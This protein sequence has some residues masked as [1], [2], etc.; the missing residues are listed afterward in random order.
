MII[1]FCIGIVLVAC[2]GWLL[3]I[4]WLNGAAG[5]N[6][7]TLCSFSYATLPALLF[8]NQISRLEAQVSRTW[9][10]IDTLVLV[11]LWS[12]P[13][14][15]SLS[16]ISSLRF[17]YVSTLLMGISVFAGRFMNVDTLALVLVLQ[18]VLQTAL[19]PSL[20]S[21]PWRHVM[22]ALD[23]PSSYI[24]L[25]LSGLLFFVSVVSLRKFKRS[26]S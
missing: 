9:P 6:I 15:F 16:G 13:W 23:T 21:T 18:L 14:L 2:E 19:W 10:F 25:L 4:P 11:I 7:G 17:A 26:T 8:R 3:N 20:S 12:I 24:A 5:V 1:V 22:F